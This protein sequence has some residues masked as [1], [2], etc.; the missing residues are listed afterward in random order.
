MRDKPSNDYIW[1]RTFSVEA[2]ETFYKEI[3]R[4]EN[5]Q[6]VTIIP[7]FI[8]S[9]G[10]DLHACLA[11]RDII[12]SCSKPVATI[13]VGTAMSAGACLLASGTRKLR[14]AAPDVRVM[15]HEAV[16]WMG[17]KATEVAED[18][19][20]LKLM[21]KIM[22]QRLADDTGQTEEAIQ[23]KLAELRNVDWHMSARE[24]KAFGI[25]DHVALP[26]PLERQFAAALAIAE[27]FQEPKPGKKRK[28]RA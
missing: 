19:R 21:T 1:V 26:R 3:L 23:A 27:P 10:G 25:I 13:A 11:M 5:A 2:V 9:Y 4:L 16:T 8:C 12:K 20:Q 17:G 22:F 18:S 24:A 7:V 14:Y 15:V 28:T 6:H